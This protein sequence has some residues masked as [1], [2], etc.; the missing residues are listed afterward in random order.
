MRSRW[1]VPWY[2]DLGYFFLYS[3][4]ICRFS[5][6]K[7]IYIYIKNIF[8]LYLFDYCRVDQWANNTITNISDRKVYYFIAK[9]KTETW[10][11]LFYFQYSIKELY[12]HIGILKQQLRFMSKRLP[13]LNYHRKLIA[14]LEHAILIGSCL[15]I[16]KLSSKTTGTFVLSVVITY[17]YIS[18]LQLIFIKKIQGIYISQSL[19]GEAD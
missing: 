16:G 19:Y 4:R 10:F 3:F 18:Y 6:N 1:R 12:N 7:Y 11:F 8:I 5:Y 17:F 13:Y 14:C 15:E 2:T 9:R